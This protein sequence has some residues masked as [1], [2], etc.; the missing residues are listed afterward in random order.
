MGGLAPEVG[1]KE[2][3]DYFSKYGT[4]Q[5]SI[6]MYDRKTNRSRG[7]GFVTFEAEESLQN[8]LRTEHE[9]M[10]KWVEI[11]RAEPREARPGGAPMD[12]MRM[13]GRGGLAMGGM[14]RGGRAGGM[15]GGRGGMMGGYDEYG[16]PGYVSQQQYMSQ[17][18]AAMR[19]NGAAAAYGGYPAA[20]RAAYGPGAVYGG[21]VT[22]RSAGVAGY[23]YASGMQGYYS[24]AA[25]AYSNYG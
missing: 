24:A 5:D 19:G 9:I 10:G 18:A 11:K 13:D 4:L 6:V 22:G 7:F 15:M 1:D 20:M 3:R 23:P 17:M 25:S 14:Y 12:M 8:V 21:A 2:F 16:A